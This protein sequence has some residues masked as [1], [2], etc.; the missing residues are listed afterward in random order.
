MPAQLEVASV[1]G[2]EAHGLTSCRI[3]LKGVMPP[4]CAPLVERLTQTYKPTSRE[5]K[6]DD[7]AAGIC[8]IARPGKISEKANKV[9]GSHQRL[10]RPLQQDRRES[11]GPGLKVPISGCR[12]L[13][14]A[15]PFRPVFA[16]IPTQSP[17]LLV[18]I[19]GVDL[20]GSHQ[21]GVTQ[22]ASGRPVVDQCFMP[23][24]Q[25]AVMRL[26]NQAFA[27]W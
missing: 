6:F 11:G 7:L 13:H 14:A 26:L 12:H 2:D 25:L 4:L 15:Q 1:P 16:Q 3:V 21:T 27:K 24:L 5:C 22:E 18:D 9:Q 20:P 19:G 8:S 23:K 10:R 17:K